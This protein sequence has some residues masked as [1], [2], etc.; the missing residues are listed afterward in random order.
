MIENWYDTYVAGTYELCST[1]LVRTYQQTSPG[2]KELLVTPPVVNQFSYSLPSIVDQRQFMIRFQ[3]SCYFLFL[4]WFKQ[5]KKD[6]IQ[7]NRC[8]DDTVAKY[9]PIVCKL[10]R[11]AARHTILPKHNFKIWG[12]KGG[13][14]CAQYV[15]LK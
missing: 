1:Y 12:G 14:G 2:A 11:K 9:P 13:R 10:I 6:N 3:P 8:V 5:L 4:W 15:K 7:S